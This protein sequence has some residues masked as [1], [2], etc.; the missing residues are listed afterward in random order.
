[1]PEL[2]P[3]IAVVVALPARALLGAIR[4]Y[5]VTLSPVLPALFGPACGCRFHPSCSSY[6][7]EAVREHRAIRGAALALWRLIR[8]SPLHPGGLD[9]VPPSRTRPRCS[10]VAAESPVSP[11]VHG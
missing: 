9:P 5:Q 10:R 11:F 4:L 8:C 2:P 7:A 1:M 6:A 3:L